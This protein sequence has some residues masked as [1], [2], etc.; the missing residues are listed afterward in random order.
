[1][2]T[3]AFPSSLELG[4]FPFFALTALPLPLGFFMPWFFLLLAGVFSF[5]LS[6]LAGLVLG[7]L[8]SL[9]NCL[10]AGGKGV[11][12]EADERNSTL[13]NLTKEKLY[14]ARDLN[15]PREIMTKLVLTMCPSR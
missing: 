2:G 5:F 8:L 11:V 9:C 1:M 4:F 13:S 3:R 7:S 6:R 15:I 10:T 14:H 12:M